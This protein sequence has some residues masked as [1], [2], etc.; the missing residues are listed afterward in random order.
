MQKHIIIFLG[1]FPVI[2]FDMEFN[3]CDARNLKKSKKLQVLQLT[4]KENAILSDV[5]K[6]GSKVTNN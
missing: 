1:K 4:G 5:E 2:L 3:K 6:R